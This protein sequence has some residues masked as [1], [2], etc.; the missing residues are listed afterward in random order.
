MGKTLWGICP[1]LLYVEPDQGSSRVVSV[2]RYGSDRY[3][4][5]GASWWS[6][7][8]R[9]IIRIPYHM[10]SRLGIAGSPYDRG[11][12]LRDCLCQI[13]QWDYLLWITGDPKITT[14]SD[15]TVIVTNVFKCH[16]CEYVRSTVYVRTVWVCR[17]V[18]D[19]LGRQLAWVVS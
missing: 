17:L 10:G 16:T 5:R 14:I 18:G 12:T 8:V 11:L 2:L 3:I 6:A 15:K 4:E 19:I 7:H 13:D 9:F 1:L